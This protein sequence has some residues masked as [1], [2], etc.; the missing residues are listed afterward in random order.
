[1]R[2]QEEESNERENNAQPP[3]RGNNSEG[4]LKG[5]THSSFFF[6]SVPLTLNWIHRDGEGVGG[7]GNQRKGNRD[8]VRLKEKEHQSEKKGEWITFRRA[9]PLRAV[10][11]ER[12]ITGQRWKRWALQTGRAEVSK[13]TLS[14]ILTRLSD[15]TP[16][17]R[18][19]AEEMRAKDREFPLFFSPTR[20]TIQGSESSS[21][22]PR[23]R[24]KKAN[25]E[26]SG[27]AESLYKKG[28]KQFWSHVPHASKAKTTHKKI[29]YSRKFLNDLIG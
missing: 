7:G 2:E 24:D 3:R 6:L 17:L 8:W 14:L 29:L 22:K 4:C 16:F 23:E 28:A 26:L 27:E 5:S 19:E 1:M 21:W 9:T 18:I 25:L 20:G 10:I 11:G 12:G 15:P 13:S